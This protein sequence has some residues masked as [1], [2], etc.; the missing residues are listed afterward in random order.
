MVSIVT[1]VVLS[2]CTLRWYWFGRY[3]GC[4]HGFGYQEKFVLIRL[5][6]F[7][8]LPNSYARD[9]GGRA[10]IDR[11]CEENVVFDFHFQR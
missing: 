10:L 5:R 8:V 6:L 7:V 1:R 9:V 4:R 2:Q 3:L 11:N